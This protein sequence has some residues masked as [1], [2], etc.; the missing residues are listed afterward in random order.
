[1]IRKF[2]LFI[3]GIALSLSAAATQQL[4]IS[5]PG[6]ATT[7]PQAATIL[8]ANFAELYAANAPF[9]SAQGAN[10]ALMAPNGL[11][12]VPAFRALVSGD[13]PSSITSAV[14]QFTNRNAGQIYVIPSGDVTGVADLANLQSAAVQVLATARLP[15]TATSY[16]PAAR[17]ILGP[18]TFYFTQ[19]NIALFTGTT[20]KMTGFWLQ[21]SGRGAT[22]ID[23]NPTS[24]GPMFVNTKWLDV[25]MSDISFVGHD[26]ASDF[27]WSQ[28]Q[29]SVSNVQ[30]YTFEDVEWSGP[31]NS[32][33]RLTGGNNNSEWKFE[34]SSVGGVITNWIYTPPAVVAT[35][36]NGSNSIAATNTAS[37]IQVGDTGQF[38][39]AVAPLSANTQYF[40]VSANATTFQVATT[41][42][43]TPVT[44]SAGGTPNFQTASDQFL[45]FWFHQ[46]KFDTGT[47]A[48]QWIN[49]NY[50]G[51]I[52]IR[53]SDISGRNP[54]ALSYVFNLLGFSHSRGVQNFEV[55]GL[56]VEHKNDNSRLMHSQ[57]AGGSIVFNNLDESSQSTLRT[58]SNVQAW[59]E[60]VNAPGPTIEYRNSQLMGV[61]LYANNTSNYRSQNEILYEMDTLLDNPTAANFITTTN[62][63]NSGG[64]PRI[65]FSKSRN[66]LDSNSAGYKE[67]VD[68]DLFWNTSQG[69]QTNVK[70]VS[71]VGANS[72]FPA[73]G[74]SFQFR[75]PMNA[76]VTQIRYWKP[77]GGGNSGAFQYTLQT[78]EGTPTVLAGGAATPMAG[79]NA[80]TLL[81][82]SSMYVTTPN[83]L[84]TT[85]AA[86]TIALIDTLGGGRTGTFTGLNC[87]IDYI[88]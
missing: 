58:I 40:V 20:L 51:S 64:M 23:Y 42:G 14:S 5:T 19:S 22:W 35:I 66:L 1:M 44:F 55:D 52:K 72:D 59:Y 61:H 17:V 24:S 9:L 46:V 65:R 4:I 6:V 3:A 56:R 54:A 71:C 38:S 86:R 33:F 75:L 2:A 18:G 49:M 36:T 27:M 8:N 11:S 73:S 74:G 82:A 12:G 87:L 26:A 81:P 25:K 13:I 76:M 48:G 47:G 7:A 53:D 29:A 31:W 45:N 88:G 37:Q 80:G 41:A 77:G 62:A 28:E 30:D 79:A 21:G 10:Q 39:A 43:G 69:G 63:G 70:T 16:S 68:T 34:R 67:I 78:T 84:M 57:W 85:D 50:G 83:F 32:L 60:I 15:P